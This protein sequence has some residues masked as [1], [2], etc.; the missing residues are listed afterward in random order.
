MQGG[1]PGDA[2]LRCESSAAREDPHFSPERLTSR[3]KSSHSLALEL[4]MQVSGAGAEV[5]LT[6]GQGVTRG[7]LVFRCECSSARGQPFSLDGP[8]CKSGS[9]FCPKTLHGWRAMSCEQVLPQSSSSRT[10]ILLG[11]VRTS[12]SESVIFHLASPRRRH[13]FEMKRNKT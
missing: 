1:T 5:A 9:R 7:V 6:G 3:S 4:P 8:P 2:V 12:L 10:L 13:F 11:L